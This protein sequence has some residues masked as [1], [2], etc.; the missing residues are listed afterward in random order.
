MAAS[1]LPEEPP[2]A[3]LFLDYISAV[4]T[5]TAPLRTFGRVGR[6]SIR[7]ERPVLA[8]HTAS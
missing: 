1:F 8:D 4:S 6:D 5:A 7:A 3:S 2:F